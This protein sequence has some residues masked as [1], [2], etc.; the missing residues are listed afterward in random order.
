MKRLR[1]PRRSFRSRGAG[2]AEVLLEERRQRRCVVEDLRAVASEG[3]VESSFSRRETSP[4]GTPARNG[5]VHPWLWVHAPACKSVATFAPLARWQAG[6]L[7]SFDMLSP[8]CSASVAR[9]ESIAGYKGQLRGG[10]VAG[11]HNTQLQRTV[12]PHRVRAASAAWP[13]CARG[14]HDTLARGR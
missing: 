3:S 8:L 12:I 11:A 10:S 6:T 1:S 7:I 5:S 4:H 2:A 9:V 14:A 13:L